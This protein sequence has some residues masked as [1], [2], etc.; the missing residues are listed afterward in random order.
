MSNHS[1]FEGM[2]KEH[3]EPIISVVYRMHQQHKLMQEQIEL[4]QQQVKTLQE[5]NRNL[6][7]RLN[8]IDKYQRDQHQS[9]Y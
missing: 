1:E 2:F 8:R 9:M 6:S 3:A 7:N 4:L 5:T